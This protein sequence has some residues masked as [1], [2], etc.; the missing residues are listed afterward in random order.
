[1]R[2]ER[3]GVE[4][5]K[6]A[7]GKKEKSN[8]PTTNHHMKCGFGGE[9]EGKKSRL[10]VDLPRSSSRDLFPASRATLLESK[11]QPLNCSETLWPMKMVKRR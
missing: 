11:I 9:G 10:R 4:S 7:K 8:V 6:I 2:G 3:E 5:R 1:V